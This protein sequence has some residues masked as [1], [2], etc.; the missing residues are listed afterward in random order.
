MSTAKPDGETDVMAVGK[1]IINAYN[2][3]F[4]APAG[5]A[6]QG[7]TQSSGT[8]DLQAS[9]GTLSVTAYTAVN[10][11]VISGNET[12]ELQVYDPVAYTTVSWNTSTWYTSQW[13]GANW[14][15]ANWQGANWQGANWQGANWQGTPDTTS[16]YG[17]N[18][19]GS[20]FY[21][22]WDHS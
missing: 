3:T 6:N 14:Q 18:W 17:A 13:T 2:A 1:G 12:L 10:T 9:R 11:P 20:A 19:Q 15:G 7:L 16:T 22:A 21:G 5:L 8:G 4:K